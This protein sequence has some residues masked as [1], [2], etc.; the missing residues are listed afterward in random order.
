MLYTAV[1]CCTVV[2]AAVVSNA[3]VYMM[4]SAEVNTPAVPHGVEVAISMLLLLLC[5][6]VDIIT[7]GM[8]ITVCIFR[9]R[10]EPVHDG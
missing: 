5:I 9:H 7:L 2:C 1:Q 8:N 3:F 10:M 4:C 6:L